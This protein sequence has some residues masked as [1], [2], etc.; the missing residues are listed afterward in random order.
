MNDENAAPAERSE[1]T[2][3]LAVLGI[4][5]AAVVSIFQ[6]DGMP[7][8]TDSLL[9]ITLAA[10]ARAYNRAIPR[11]P[12]ESL[13]YAMVV[14]A[15]VYL[16]VAGVFHVFTTDTFRGSIDAFFP[17][18]YWAATVWILVAAICFIDRVEFDRS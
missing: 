6:S 13:A 15:A 5:V 4:L 12:A 9:G 18:D 7:S 8:L 10:V 3:T 16:M 2:L 14:G 11:A 17:D 1:P